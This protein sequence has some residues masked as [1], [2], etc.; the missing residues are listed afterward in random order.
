MTTPSRIR[1]G[2][3]QWTLSD[4]TWATRR[5]AEIGAEHDRERRRG[6]DH[7]AAGE[8]RDHQRGRGAALQDAGDAEAGQEGGEAVAQRD[9]QQ[10]AQVGAEGPRRMPVRTMR[11][12][13]SSSAAAPS[14]SIRMSVADVARDGR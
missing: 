6:L 3:S 10:V 13:H 9:P 11:V 4:S 5:G 12:P 8:G 14:S 7:A 1:S 2:A